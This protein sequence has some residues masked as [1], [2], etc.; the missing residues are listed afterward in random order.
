[1]DDARALLDSLMGAT[2]NEHPKDKKRQEHYTDRDICKY[3]LVDCCPHQLF[4][5]TVTG[6][7][8]VNS[9]LGEC[10]KQHSEFM[11]TQFNDAL[12]GTG[13]EAEDAQRHKRTYE[14]ELMRYMKRLVSDCNYKITKEKANMERKGTLTK[15]RREQGLTPMNQEQLTEHKIIGL[16]KAMQ[17]KLKEAELLAEDGKIAQSQEMMKEV[18]ALKDAIN[19]QSSVAKPQSTLVEDIGD[20]FQED[21]CEVCGLT[22]DWRCAM[23]IENRRKGIPHPHTS[24]TYHQ[25]FEQMRAKLAELEE[26]YADDEEQAAKDR[27][28]DKR[29]P[30]EKASSSTR[31][32]RDDR[33]SPD[34]DGDRRRRSRSPRGRDRD[35]RDRGRDRDEDRRGGSN[36]DRRGGGRSYND[37]DR[38]R[39][40]GRGDQGGGGRS[41]RR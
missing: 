10:P 6:K 20:T 2:R 1:M 41:Y 7:A 13:K 5:T 25:G 19:A 38:D 17:D 15:R 37:G 29:A 18:Q 30:E 27:E 23:E 12:K 31:D 14:R 11:K 33:R 8:A 24:G 39:R 34:R 36:H 21:V 16:K 28:A 32:G 35:T 22:I 40:G 4:Y 3:W 9:P 26:K